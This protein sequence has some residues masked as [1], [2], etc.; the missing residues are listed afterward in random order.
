M[1]NLSSSKLNGKHG[2]RASK[3][4]I[5][6]SL[7]QIVMNP[8]GNVFSDFY[9]LDCCYQMAPTNAQEHSLE[10]TFLYHELFITQISLKT[11]PT[12]YN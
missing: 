10:S 1:L 9:S 4:K 8:K 5:S 11:P 12:V 6:I 3:Q 2:E 7:C